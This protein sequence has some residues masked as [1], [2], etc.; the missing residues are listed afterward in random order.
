MYRVAVP[1]S[2]TMNFWQTLPK[3]I[4]VLA[5]LADVTDAAFR[6]II[7]KYS[8][9]GGELP[10]TEGG[11]TRP[12]SQKLGGPDVMWTEFVSADGLIRADKE[13]KQKLLADLMYSE[14]ERPI[15]AQLFSSHPEYMEQ[16][17]ALCAELGFDGIDINMGCP[18]KGIEKQGCG[19]AMMKNPEL[20]IEIIHVAKRGAPNLPVSVK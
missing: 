5:P 8:K 13:G 9:W 17:A 1:I 3:P 16:A 20:A 7:A 2:V 6:R 12:L 11:F 4:M 14:E 10:Q 15:V 19:A 18:D